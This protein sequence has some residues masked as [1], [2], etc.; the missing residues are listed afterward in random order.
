MVV[1]WGQLFFYF[2]FLKN[3]VL[4]RVD[5]RCFV[6]FCCAAEW[7][8]YTYIYI[9]IYILF[10]IIFPIMFHHEWLDIVPCAI[11]RGLIAYHPKFSS[12]HLLTPNSRCIPLP[13]LPLGNHKFILYVLECVSVVYTGSFVPYFRLCTW[14]I[15]DSLRLSLSGWDFLVPAS[16]PL[17]RLCQVPSVWGDHL[18]F[19]ASQQRYL[20]F[21]LNSHDSGKPLE[22]SEGR[23]CVLV[24]CTVPASGTGFKMLVTWLTSGPFTDDIIWFYDGKAFGD[25]QTDR[26]THHPALSDLLFLLYCSSFYVR[27]GPA[28]IVRA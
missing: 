18:V 23:D 16:I 26:Q 25:R 22:L 19:W 8:I 27:W 2:S 24:T 12:L 14:V 4:I 11:Q 6:N 20:W 1:S 10:L 21:Q 13:S 3:F 15:P 5:S 9:C 17:W 7:P 28:S